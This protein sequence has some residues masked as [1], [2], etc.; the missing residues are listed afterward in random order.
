[1]SPLNLRSWI[2]RASRDPSF[3]L[4]KKDKKEGDLE[5]FEKH[6]CHYD[7]E[8]YRDLLQMIYHAAVRNTEKNKE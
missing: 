7:F 2:E 5:F 1:V 3:P 6:A 4:L 8:T